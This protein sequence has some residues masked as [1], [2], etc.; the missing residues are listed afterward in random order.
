MISFIII[1]QVFLFVFNVLNAL[2]IH[3]NIR[4]KSEDTRSKSHL[5]RLTGHKPITI[6][7]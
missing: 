1:T 5:L 3:Y 6:N 2:I 4:D 7:K